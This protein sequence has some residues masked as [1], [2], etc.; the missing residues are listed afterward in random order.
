MH[1]KWIEILSRTL[2][3]HDIELKDLSG[4]MNCIRPKMM[5]FKK[6]KYVAL[7]GD[8]FEGIGILLE[9]SAT[10]LKESVSGN[11]VIMSILQPG[12]MFGEMA[13]FSSFGK[14]PATVQ[15]QEDSKVIFISS[16]KIVDNCP[17]NCAGHK[18]LIMNMLRI[19]SEKALSLNKKVEYLT[20]KSMRGKL[21]TFLLEQYYKNEKKTF[22]LP[23]NRN[24]LAD[25]LNVSRP[26]MS[27]EMSRMRDEG[28]IDYYMSSFQIKD[29]E[30]LKKMAE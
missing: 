15:A 28:V 7:T 25:F 5:F 24:E 10:V 11:R 26:S 23:M 19:I 2:L 3:F 4:M 9:G 13:A 1:E 17:H 14:W 20:I 29:V 30:T 21:S 16:E 12:D 8:K 18:M 22:M 6:N 27:R